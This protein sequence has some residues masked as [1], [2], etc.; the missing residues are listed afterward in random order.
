VTEPPPQRQSPQEPLFVVLLADLELGDKDVEGAIPVAWLERALEGTEAAARDLPGHLD[1]TVSK[2][3]RDVMIRGRIQ[4]A[5]TMP[6]SRTLEPTDVDIDADVFLM[7][8]PQG[9]EEP[10]V[11]RKRAGGRTARASRKDRARATQAGTRGKRRGQA[12]EP[13]TEDRELSAEDA[14]QDTYSGE[15]I[16]LDRFFREFI[17]LELPL[18]PLHPNSSPAISP[19]SSEPSDA[20]GSPRDPRLAPLAALAGR[21]RK[22]KD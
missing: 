21:M 8:A 20:E 5:L 16:V 18:F 3:G 10:D 1:V 12:A 4:V 19:P 11:A 14:A 22:D 13:D 15:R 17:L 7:L 2:S 9:S 6:C